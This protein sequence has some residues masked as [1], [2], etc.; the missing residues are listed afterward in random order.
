M[1]AGEGQKA[2]LLKP[3]TRWLQTRGF[4][5]RQE[6]RV[7][8]GK[9]TDT[10]LV[11][12]FRKG[13]HAAFSELISRYSEKAHNLAMRFTRNQEDAEEVLQDV[14]ITVYNKIDGFKGESAFSSWL[15]RITVNTSFMKLRKRKQTAAVSLEEITPSVKESWVANRSDAADVNY[16]YSRHE[17]RAELDEAIQRLPEEYRIIFMLRDVDGLSNQEVGEILNISVPAVKSRLHRSRL[18]LRKRL[19]R[20]YEDYSSNEKIA[21]GDEIESEYL[22][23]A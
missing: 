10:E 21:Y 5:V 16:L 18:M 13:D 20:F 12:M 7:E 1:L 4:T 17:L 8:Q 14:F 9:L 15:Y 6:K 2:I 23:A 22:K 11:A 19:A 3:E